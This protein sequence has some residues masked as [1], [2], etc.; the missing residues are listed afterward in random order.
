M[1]I[2]LILKDLLLIKHHIIFLILLATIIPALFSNTAGLN[3]EFIFTLTVI[4]TVLSTYQDISIEEEKYPNATLLLCTLPISRKLIVLAKYLLAFFSYIICIIICISV[5]LLL[6]KSIYL[7]F[8]LISQNL[9][10]L[11]LVLSI[12]IPLQYCFGHSIVKYIFSITCVSTPFLISYLSRFNIR[13]DWSLIWVN[14][15][16]FIV[17]FVIYYISYI[18]SCLIFNKKDF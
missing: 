2:R 15:M 7:N 16:I 4:I 10:Y 13:G 3:D 14:L 9:F 17:S 12:C 5:T 8:N 1:V 6:R 18:I 11:L